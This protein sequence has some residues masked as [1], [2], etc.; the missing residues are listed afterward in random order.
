MKTVLSGLII[1]IY[2]FLLNFNNYTSNYI[3][4]DHVGSIDKPIST[5]KITDDQTDTLKESNLFLP[6]PK[7]YIVQPVIYKN[8]KHLVTL[9]QGN[10][11][12]DPYDFGTF[13]CK[14]YEKG[15]L[16]TKCILDRKKAIVLFDKLIIDLKKTQ[17]NEDLIAS[18]ENNKQRINY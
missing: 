18:L 9:T 5:I 13:E 6:P 10:Y 14:V 4:I 17:G 2:S 11:K 7:K 3:V 8:L 1:L 15:G 12:I 16:R